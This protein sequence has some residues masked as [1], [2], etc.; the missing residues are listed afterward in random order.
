VEK[1]AVGKV[2]PRTSVFS[3][4]SIP[5]IELTDLPLGVVLIEGQNG[6]I[7]NRPKKAI[8]FINWFISDE[9][10]FQLFSSKY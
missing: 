8:I 5:L 4:S 6:Q 1:L 7:G 10:Y 3:V 9:K 2:V